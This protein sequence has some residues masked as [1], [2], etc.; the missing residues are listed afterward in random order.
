MGPT[1][2]LRLFNYYLP[3]TVTRVLLSLAD[4]F[5]LVFQSFDNFLKRRTV[6]QYLKTKAPGADGPGYICGIA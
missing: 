5:V 6:L 1:P 3:F 2:A 4:Y